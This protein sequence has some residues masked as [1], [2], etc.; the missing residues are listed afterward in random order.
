MIYKE[1]FFT[2]TDIIIKSIFT[3]IAVDKKWMVQTFFYCFSSTF[4]WLCTCSFLFLD[5][6]IS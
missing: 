6:S 1:V 2:L 5:E 3:Q 4:H